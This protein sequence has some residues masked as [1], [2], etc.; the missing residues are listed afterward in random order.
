MKFCCETIGGVRG[1]IAQLLVAAG[2][3]KLRYVSRSPFHAYS[4]YPFAAP[5]CSSMIS[6]GCWSAQTNH[7]NSKAKF[8]WLEATPSENTGTRLP[9][10]PTSQHLRFR[11]PRVQAKAAWQE[12]FA[13]GCLG[14]CLEWQGSSL[15]R[16]RKKI[17]LDQVGRQDGRIL[18]V[19]SPHQQ[20]LWASCLTQE[21]QLTAQFPVDVGIFGP[22]GCTLCTA[23]GSTLENAQQCLRWWRH[24]LPAHCISLSPILYPL[25]RPV[26]TRQA[27]ANGRMRGGLLGSFPHVHLC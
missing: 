17:S 25:R 14:S 1:E 11:N 18:K 3:C 15:F 6:Y 21:L 5:P 12:D 9:L 7:E 4:H 16:D 19:L 26:S 20:L 27:A 22:D 8:L 2:L 13:L 23:P 24:C 10:D